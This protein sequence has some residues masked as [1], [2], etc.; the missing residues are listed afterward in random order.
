MTEYVVS[1]DTRVATT[2]VAFLMKADVPVELSGVRE[3]AALMAGAMPVAGKAPE[4][5]EPNEDEIRERVR[6]A[7][8]TIVDEGSDLNATGK[9]KLLEV[10]KYVP[11]ATPQ[12]RDEVWET[13]FESEQ[14]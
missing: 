13:F 7:I 5:K 14:V 2:Q 8:R 11:E 12:M 10:R 6:D 1:T 4:I 9:P 3:R